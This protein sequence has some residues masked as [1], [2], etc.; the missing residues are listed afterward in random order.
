MTFKRKAVTAQTLTVLLLAYKERLQLWAAT[1]PGRRKL[2]PD[3]IH[4][5]LCSAHYL[6]Y[7][8]TF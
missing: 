2:G 6:S 4:T 1:I 7:T 3:E 5:L 8:E